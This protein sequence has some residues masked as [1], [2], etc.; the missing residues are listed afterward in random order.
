MAPRLIAIAGP[1][2][3]TSVPL[4][5]SELSVG[6]DHVN[7]VT[8]AD[9]SVSAY[10]C[11]FACADGRVTIT[12]LDPT[13]PSFVNGLPASGDRTLEDG[14][15]IQIGASVFVLQLSEAGTVASPDS[16][17]VE[18][19]W[20]Y[21]SS[22]A[23]GFAGGGIAFVPGWYT[24]ASVSVDVQML[25]VLPHAHYLCKRMEGFTTLPDGTRKWLLLIKNWDF[26]WQGDYQYRTPVVLPRGTKL[27][28]RYSYDNSTNNVANPNMPP[29]RVKYGPQSGDEMAE[30]WFQLLPANQTDSKALA[31]ADADAKRAIATNHDQ[32]TAQR[33]SDRPAGAVQ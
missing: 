13:N 11:V 31:E 14:D 12:D 8:L 21:M 29:L 33:A 2:R 26:N 20:Y 25:G 16:V 28:M 23:P 24:D 19:G 18:D 6:R 17:R 10:H 3:G 30:L 9:G 32:E 15:Q 4:T 5:R 22:P 27:S 1:L 7:A